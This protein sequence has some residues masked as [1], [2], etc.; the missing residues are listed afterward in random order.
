MPDIREMNRR[1]PEEV[2]DSRELER[3]AK[4]KAAERV[5]REMNKKFVDQHDMT[6]VANARGGPRLKD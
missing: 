2:F 4:A 3:Q 5:S 1:H 6:D